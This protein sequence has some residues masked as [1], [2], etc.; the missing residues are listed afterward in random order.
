MAGGDQVAIYDTDC[1]K[2]RNCPACWLSRY[3]NSFCA[4][5]AIAGSVGSLPKVHNMDIQYAQSAVLR[6]LIFLFQVM[7]SKPKLLQ[8]RKLH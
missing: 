4:V 2:I 1:G 7:V 5:Y 8:I 3:A 6:L